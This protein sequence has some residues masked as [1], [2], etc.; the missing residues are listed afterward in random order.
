MKILL[1][2]IFALLLNICVFAQKEIRPRFYHFKGFIAQ[3][4]SVSMDLII[5]KKYVSGVSYCRNSPGFFFVK[6]MIQ[7]DGKIQIVELQNNIEAGIFVGQIKG[8]IFSG[9]WQNIVNRKKTAFNMRNDFS[10]SIGAIKFFRYKN[11]IQLNNDYSK[12]AYLLKFSFIY[13]V[14]PINNN[15]QL[16]IIK[17]LNNKYFGEQCFYPAMCLSNYVRTI[18]N[19]IE[20]SSLLS[21]TAEE[22]KSFVSTKLLYNDNNF[23]TIEKRKIV[24][25]GKI[26]DA[27]QVSYYNFDIKTGKL[28]DLKDIFNKNKNKEVVE[29]IK[30][31]IVAIDSDDIVM[32]NITIPRNFA[33]VNGGIIFRYGNFGEN[34]FLNPQS[35]VLLRFADIK[36]CLTPAFRQRI[37]L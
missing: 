18:T 13:P 1:S 4:D 31:N 14:V 2:A 20:D 35:T 24:Y 16:A 30:Q 11:N 23:F 17:T 8:N 37:G 32:N 34:D 3:K 21:K 28:Y 19:N 36:D 33:I 15:S 25:E 26:Q 7:S 5:G 22:C 27:N 9:T 6:G 12:S 10:E 29:K